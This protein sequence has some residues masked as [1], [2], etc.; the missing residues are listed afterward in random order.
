MV[1]PTFQAVI[2]D[3]FE[4]LRDGDSNPYLNRAVQS[5]LMQQIQ[6]TT[7]PNL[8][9]RDTNT[10]VMQP[11]AFIATQRGASDVTIAQL[12]QITATGH[13]AP[14]MTMPRLQANRMWTTQ[15][16]LVLV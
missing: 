4:N 12:L 8:I 3:Q 9:E 1:G 14:M 11:D 15:L 6:D 7:L 16:L 5:A 2:A 10:A 13:R